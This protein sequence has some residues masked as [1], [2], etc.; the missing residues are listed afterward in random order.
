MALPVSIG[1]MI[2]LAKYAYKL[3]NSCKAARGQFEQIGKEV[4]AM[5][6]VIELVCANCQDP[7]IVKIAGGKKSSIWQNLRVHIRNCKQALSDVDL[8]LK[9]YQNMTLLDR[10]AWAVRGGS[11]VADLESNLSSFATQLDSFI[12]NLTLRGVGMFGAQ[13]SQLQSGVGRLGRVEEELEKHD[14]D[15]AA[16]VKKCMRD[17]K[18]SGISQDTAGHY[19]RIFHDYAQE[20]RRSETSPNMQRSPTPDPPRNQN[21]R[22]SVPGSAHRSRSASTS[23]S[24]KA[25]QATRSPFNNP[26]GSNR[27]KYFLECWL[28]QIK[29]ADAMFVTFKRDIKEKQMRGQWKLEQMAKQFQSCSYI[30]RLANDHDLVNWVLEDR[31]KAEQDPDY[32]WQPFTAK[33]ERKS[34]FFLGLGIEEQAMVIIKRQMTREAQKK[35][36][37]EAR[38]K[39]E[40]LAALKKKIAEETAKKKK[41]DEEAAKKKKADEEAA[42]KKRAD[43]EAVKK[44]KADE[45]AAK[46]KKTDEEAAKKRKADEEAAKKKKADEESGQKKKTDEEARKKMLENESAQQRVARAQRVK[47]ELEQER[48]NGKGKGKEPQKGKRGEQQDK[49]QEQNPR[50][51]DRDNKK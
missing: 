46:K 44:K 49:K 31:R 48:L 34:S 50:R 39:A 42:K 24:S 25:N 20:V 6:T 18:N 3:W 41:A 40:K 4:F 12:M 13:L 23:N 33:I 22:L 7:Y 37:E 16:A 28:I 15:D 36:D 47:N 21:R 27:R 43:E 11:E 14:G 38:I 9:K 2:D 8:L 29:S 51:V 19:T 32:T 30:S 35:A 45:E 17:V 5:R 26:A 10:V 1:E